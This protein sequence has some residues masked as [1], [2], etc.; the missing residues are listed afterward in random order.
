MTLKKKTYRTVP[1]PRINKHISFLFAI[2]K[3]EVSLHKY[4][5]R[6]ILSFILLLS[7]LL[8]PLS[9]HT[10]V[11]LCFWNHTLS[12]LEGTSG[13]LASSVTRRRGDG[14]ERDLPKTRQ[15]AAVES[16]LEPAAFFG[17][18]SPTFL[19][20]PQVGQATGFSLGPD[21]VTRAHPIVLFRNLT[22]CLFSPCSTPCF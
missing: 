10:P 22:D 7:L 17:D 5:F 4:S 3:G 13:C 19:L 20:H 18:S 9:N 16:N 14:R 21:P 2:M 8:S 15:E 11:V 12:A 6:N 1:T